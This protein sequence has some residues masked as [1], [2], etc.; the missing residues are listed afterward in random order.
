MHRTNSEYAPR[1]PAT[2][3]QHMEPPI[4]GTGDEN[5]RNGPMALILGLGMPAGGGLAKLRMKGGV[6]GDN[7]G[8]RFASID[9]APP[10]PDLRKDLP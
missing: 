3:N 2:P 8:L 6:Q 1:S 9:R 4:E 10:V 7:Q 5:A